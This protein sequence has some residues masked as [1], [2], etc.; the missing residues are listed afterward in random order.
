MSTQN[1]YRIRALKKAKLFNLDNRVL[2]PVWEETTV[3]ENPSEDQIV[4]YSNGAW[5]NVDR[6]DF[7]PDGLSNLSDVVFQTN[8]SNDQFL[9]YK[10]GV[11]FEVRTANDTGSS[12]DLDFIFTVIQSKAVVITGG[13]VGATGAKSF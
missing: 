12:A 11:G 5:R 2:N 3:I 9:V 7:V 6:L 8:V 13:V 1:S 10:T 4:V